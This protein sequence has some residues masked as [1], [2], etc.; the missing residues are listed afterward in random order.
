MSEEVCS[1]CNNTG[2]VVLKG[3]YKGFEKYYSLECCCNCKYG[4]KARGHNM[5]CSQNNEPCDC[6]YRYILDKWKDKK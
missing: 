2:L 4:S 1:H 6:E 3:L 5:M